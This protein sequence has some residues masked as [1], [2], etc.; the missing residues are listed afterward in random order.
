MGKF[1]EQATSLNRDRISNNEES[2]ND[3]KAQLEAAMASS[4]YAE[5]A[6]LG[7][8]MD[9]LKGQKEKFI[10]ADRDEADTENAERNFKTEKITDGAEDEKK[11]NMEGREKELAIEIS[12]N[13]EEL[14]K[15]TEN[16]EKIAEDENLTPSFRERL[17]S[18]IDAIG[19]NALKKVSKHLGGAAVA[20]AI[21]GVNE[22]LINMADKA[23][24]GY[25]ESG[26]MFGNANKVVLAGIA[27]YAGIKFLQFAKYK[28]EEQMIKKGIKKGTKRG[29]TDAAS[30]IHNKAFEDVKGEEAEKLQEKMQI[31]HGEHMGL[32]GENL[33][34]YNEEKYGAEYG[35]NGVARERWKK[36]NERIRI[37]M[38]TMLKN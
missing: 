37:E 8:Q 30:F 32:Y 1:E 3:I 11:E 25:I 34:V 21:F 29:A 35:Y 26:S 9:A 15:T 18:S 22:Y 24:G 28:I 27:V 13:L 6:K 10:D 7:G 23:G 38:S 17:L 14:G 36:S 2:A 33:S 12:G 20:G 16:I 31:T 5:V 19:N 4:D